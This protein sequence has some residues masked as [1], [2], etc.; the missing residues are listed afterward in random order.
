MIEF[1][2]FLII[3]LLLLIT[4]QIVSKDKNKKN[5][6]INSNP[7]HL[8]M[9]QTETTQNLKNFTLTGWYEFNEKF[10][11]IHLISFY[12]F[13]S[14]NLI[15]NNIEEHDKCPI[16]PFYLLKNKK[17]FEKFNLKKNK[18]CFFSKTKN[19]KKKIKNEIIN[20]IE[21]SI[22]KDKIE[23]YNFIF[24]FPIFIN[25]K[26]N[27]VRYSIHKLKNLNFV[28]NDK[29][30][31][32]VDFDLEKSVVKIVLKNL[33]KLETNLPEK[34]YLKDQNETYKKE[35]KIK[36][37][38]FF[39]EKIQSLSIS[40]NL[41]KNSKKNFGKIFNLKLFYFSF[42]N[43]EYLSLVN[44]DDSKKLTEI[45]TDL[46]FGN[47]KNELIEYKGSLNIKN[48]IVEENLKNE[49]YGKFLFLGKID[50]SKN[51][52]NLESPTFFFFISIK[53]AFKEA[54]ILKAS[55]KDEN[56]IISFHK[57]KKSKKFYFFQITIKKEKKIIIYKTKSFLYNKKNLKFAL[58]I[59]SNFGLGPSFL[60]FN[61]NNKIELSQNFPKFFNPKNFSYHILKSK[62]NIFIERMT[63]ISNPLSFILM[64]SKNDYLIQKLKL[65][66]IPLLNNNFCLFCKNSVIS[67]IDKK[68]VEYCPKGFHNLGGVCIKCKNPDCGSFGKIKLDV[69]RINKN[70]FFISSSKKLKN[71][72][73]KDFSNLFTFSLKGKKNLKKNDFEFEI[74]KLDNS[75]FVLKINNKVNIYNST[76]TI[77][78]NLTDKIQIY[79]TK[80]N[81]INALE[82]KID[83]LN[84]LILDSYY[85]K[86]IHILAYI[87]IS[88]YF[89]IIIISFFIFFITDRYNIKEF[90]CKKFLRSFQNIHLYCFL[91]IFNISFPANLHKFLNIMYFFV[92]KCN[93]LF[94]NYKDD[95]KKN[96][97]SDKNYFGFNVWSSTF[98]SNFNLV[99]ILQMI[100]LA[101][102][103]LIRFL[104]CLRTKFS[105]QFNDVLVK[106]KDLFEFNPIL[107]F[108]FAFSY[109]FSIFIA[110]DL[111]ESRPINHFIFSKIVIYLYF[112]VIFVIVVINVIVY[113]KKRCFLNKSDIKFK[114]SFLFIGYKNNKF[115]NFFEI[116]I[117]LIQIVSGFVL[118][119]FRFNSKLQ[120]YIF[121]SMYSC[122]FLA[123]LIIRPF[124]NIIE[125]VFEILKKMIFLGILGIINYLYFLEKNKIY[126]NDLR[127]KLGWIIIFSIVGHLLIDFLVSII[128]FTVFI[129]KIKSSSKLVFF[130]PGFV[131]SGIQEDSEK[132]P[133]KTANYF[134]DNKESKG[135]G[136]MGHLDKDK[137][138]TKNK[139]SESYLT[140]SYDSFNEDNHS[141]SNLRRF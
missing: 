130:D 52:N 59:I 21:I 133:I 54:I 41:E 78:S 38:N 96:L 8:I 70:D 56:L 43:L 16:S 81:Y 111:K 115:S 35:F 17:V 99:L 47:D 74:S 34:I 132:T 20:L 138:N 22:E 122:Y 51:E 60:F 46:I 124:E 92:I 125:Y 88:I 18:N 30:F 114:L 79:D 102:F 2:K 131:L 86:L 140:N 94:S 4:K 107:I 112:I 71:I 82:A 80:R 13:K 141:L 116:L 58:S 33:K 69:V 49:K 11:N 97:K 32:G 100:F 76:L 67:N 108:F 134:E 127:Q 106:I 10:E 84:F 9:E 12:N 62:K 23:G 72:N 39:I 77:K 14:D 117:F 91:L 36:I 113:F 90:F 31:F 63:L 44:F 105:I 126:N 19:L 104:Y 6:I 75:D 135:V 101:F 57:V 61:P 137:E 7:K 73:K 15:L 129:Y 139:G 66:E 83:N 65:C 28:K 27:V 29:V 118:G 98:W 121:I 103:L 5:Y 37:N 136:K 64:T 95:L 87:I 3:L 1:K 42:Q 128:Q 68:C 123:L 26:K 48:F 24:K 85:E 40:E 45:K 120:I 53:K 50:K 110:I 93:G 119:F 89:I 109:V 25:R 55:K